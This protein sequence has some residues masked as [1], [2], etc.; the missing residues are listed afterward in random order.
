MNR[1]AASRTA[2]YSSEYVVP[3]VSSVS[4]EVETGFKTN[5]L[6]VLAVLVRKAEQ[7]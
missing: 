6:R 1:L 4:V 7:L 5:G 2:V 3:A